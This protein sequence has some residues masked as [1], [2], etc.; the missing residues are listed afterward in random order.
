MD[1]RVRHHRAVGGRQGDADP[2]ADGAPCRGL[3]LSDLGDDARAAPGRGTTA[4]TTTSSRARSSTRKRRRSGAF[5]E[6][7]DYAGR[8]YGTLRSELDRRACGR[9][10]AGRARDRGAGR[11]PGARRDARGGAGV[12]RAAVAR[13]AAH[14]PH[15]GAGTD[16]GAEVERRL[17]GRRAGARPRSPEFAHVVVNDR[18]DEAL[19][20]LSAIVA[21]DLTSPRRGR[22]P[23]RGTARS[24][25]A[26]A[27]DRRTRTT[28]KGHHHRDSPASIVCRAGPTPTTPGVVAAKRARQINSYYHNLGE[29]TFDEFPPPMSKPLPKT[30]SRSPSRR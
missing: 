1:A 16:D 27:A 22:A 11:A 24:G 10:R 9:G 7:A 20:R 5:V 26:G 14:A 18:L 13:G 23:P 21:A 12:H 3:E 15:R 17:R 2:R 6:H 28:R 30:T 29:G 4:P 25:C 19:E 8:S